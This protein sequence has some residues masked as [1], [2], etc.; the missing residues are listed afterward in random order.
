MDRSFY[1]FVL[2]FRGGGKGD[3]NALFAESVFNDL[4]FPKEEKAFDPLS[5]YIEEKAD[6]QMPSAIF[7]E[8][9]TL[10]EERFPQ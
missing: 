10:Y 2:S 5:R 6:P 4:S 8:L 1:R 3:L 9:Y 7:D